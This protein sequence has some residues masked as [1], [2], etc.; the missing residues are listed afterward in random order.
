MERYVEDACGLVAALILLPI[1]LL[2][3]LPAAFLFDQH[4]GLSRRG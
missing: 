1:M 2:I 4:I 3:V